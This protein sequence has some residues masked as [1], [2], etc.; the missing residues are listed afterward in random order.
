[1]PHDDKKFTG[2][3]G[4]NIG[5]KDFNKETTGRNVWE[6]GNKVSSGDLKG[7]SG[8]VGKSSTIQGGKVG[9]SQT[10]SQGGFS[11]TSGKLDK[12]IEGKDKDTTG[13]GKFNKKR[14]A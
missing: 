11:K 10:G 9:T 14:A 13:K 3:Q 12:G 7:K 1:M 2:K 8:D 4:Q 5:G 6:T